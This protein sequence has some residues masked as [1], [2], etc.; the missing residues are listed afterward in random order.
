[1]ERA[2]MRTR[3]AICLALFAVA[4]AVP[5]HGDAYPK[6][7]VAPLCHGIVAQSD[8]QEGLQSVTFEQCM[9]DEQDD[10]NE[11]IKEW[12]TFSAADKRH[13]IAEA[14]MGGESSYTDLITCLEMARDVR[15]L[16]KPVPSSNQ[17]AGQ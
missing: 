8:L 2:G 16:P 6:L 15:N 3:S 17:N 14:T 9:K 12:S 4:Y 7:D 5:A 10:R 13:C 11:M 1:M